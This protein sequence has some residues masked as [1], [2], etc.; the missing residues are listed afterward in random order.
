VS[1][2][3]H[4]AGESGSAST[5]D[6]WFVEGYGV[7][8]APGG[9]LVLNHYLPAA[10]GQ[11]QLRRRFEACGACPRAERRNCEIRLRFGY[12]DALSLT[13]DGHEVYAGECTFSGFGDRA[14]RGYAEL[15]YA[16][17]RET[18]TPGTHTLV[19]TLRVSEPFGWG[20]VL[21]GEGAGLRWL[22][23]GFG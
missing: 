17:V 14:A 15:G 12:S 8:S 16:E 19:A 9:R 22:P 23:A 10:M 13:L 5:V 7:V 6:A 18:V 1:I 20:L 11:A 3:G 4:S 2:A 21:A